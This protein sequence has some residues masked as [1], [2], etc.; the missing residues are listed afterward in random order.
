[1]QGPKS[2]PR[3]CHRNG[4]FF[5]ADAA[6]G[7]EPGSWY[8]RAAVHWSAAILPPGLGPLHLYGLAVVLSPLQ[9]PGLPRKQEGPDQPWGIGLGDCPV[10][11]ASPCCSSSR[12]LHCPRNEEMLDPCP[13]VPAVVRLICSTITRGHLVM[14][15]AEPWLLVFNWFQKCVLR[16]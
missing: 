15:I 16:C 7:M 9:S 14:A 3:Q 5:L 10:P 12:A 6:P 1:M 4:C 8:S 13:G 11:F 2:H